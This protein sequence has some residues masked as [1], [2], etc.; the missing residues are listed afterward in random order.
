MHGGTIQN[1]ATVSRNT[2]SVTTTNQARTHPQNAIRKDEEA[3]QGVGVDRE[4]KG[5]MRASKHSR[6]KH[7]DH[8]KKKIHDPIP[9]I[10]RTPLDCSFRSWPKR[11]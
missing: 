4:E 3:R 5:G 11:G 7:H 2:M 9:Q 1:V 8:P 6:A 10:A